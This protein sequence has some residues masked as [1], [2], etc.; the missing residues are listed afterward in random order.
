MALW[1]RAWHAQHDLSAHSG[2]ASGPDWCSMANSTAARMIWLARSA[3]CACQPMAR[4]AMASA[5]QSR[6]FA[7]EAALPNWLDPMFWNNGNAGKRKMAFIRLWW[8]M[9]RGK[10]S[11]VVSLCAMQITKKFSLSRITLLRR[12]ARHWSIICQA[13]VC[14]PCG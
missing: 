5:V 12:M 9:T 7:A 11:Q 8:S 1:R 4:S 3:M 13:R 6:D 2:P 14:K 10:E